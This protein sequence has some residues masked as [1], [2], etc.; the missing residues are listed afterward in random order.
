M[1]A[2][3]KNIVGTLQAAAKAHPDV[4]L[5]DKAASIAKRIAGNLANVGVYKDHFPLE[6]Y[7]EIDGYDPGPEFDPILH[8][9]PGIG[10]VRYVR[11][12]QAP[13]PSRQTGHVSEPTT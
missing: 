4:D 12:E 7:V 6:V 9:A 2:L 3:I 10:R 11:F 8:F 13:D 5:S 1:N